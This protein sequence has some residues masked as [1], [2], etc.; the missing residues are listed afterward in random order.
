MQSGIKESDWWRAQSIGAATTGSVQSIREF[1]L[2]EVNMMAISQDATANAN[3]VSELNSL[4]LRESLLSKRGTPTWELALEYPCQGDWTEAEYLSLDTGRLIEFN[5][6]VLEF[7]PIQKTLHARISRYISALLREYVV[8]RNIGEVL[9]APCPIR[10][11]ARKLR[12]PD[13]LYLSHQRIPQEDTPPI[14]ADLVVEII[15]PGTE[16]QRRDTET[17]RDEYAEAGIPEYWI[18]DPDHET[19]TV[20]TLVGRIYEL[21]NEFPAGTTAGSVL[22]PGFEV[23]V[24]ATFAAARPPLT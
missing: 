23:N 16:I 21:H 9:W 12:E 7:L 19:I 13:I 22:L 1:I 8:S 6:G 3:G 15:S 11:A 18:V 24:S 4:T 5:D 20:L 2:P 10:V 14:G 17:K